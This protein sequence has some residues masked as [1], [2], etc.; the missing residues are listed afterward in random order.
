MA[1][2]AHESNA[3]RNQSVAQFSRF[4]CREDETNI[5][6]HDAQSGYQLHQL[7]IAKLTDGLELAR[8]GAQARQ[9]NRQLGF[10][11]IAQQIIGMCRQSQRFP[12]PIT[13]TK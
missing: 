4:P 13:Q 12:P 6:K 5:W 2:G 11:T 3:E 9:G 7:T 10:P 8:T 1:A